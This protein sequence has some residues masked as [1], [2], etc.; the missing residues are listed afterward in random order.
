MISSVSA[1][2]PR[3]RVGA[4]HLRPYAQPPNSQK[5]VQI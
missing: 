4:T 5:V 2:L 3:N 1:A